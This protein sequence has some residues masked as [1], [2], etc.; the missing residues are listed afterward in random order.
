MCCVCVVCNSRLPHSSL[1]QRSPTA[2]A[3]RATLSDS[4]R[5]GQSTTGAALWP[6]VVVGE[7][8]H[9][10]LSPRATTPHATPRLKPLIVV[11]KT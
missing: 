4:F 7:C 6:T 3:F 1:R 8:L 10:D 5:H 2:V 9:Y 11:K